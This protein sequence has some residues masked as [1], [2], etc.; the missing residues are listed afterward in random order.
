[1]LVSPCANSVP[2]APSP[3]V[4]LP[5]N[6]A[7]NIPP[8]R[9]R[10]ADKCGGDRAAQ[11]PDKGRAGQ[12]CCDPNRFSDKIDFLQITGKQR[13]LLYP[14]AGTDLLVEAKEASADAL[15]TNKVVPK[16][17][18]HGVIGLRKRPLKSDLIS[19][20]GAPVAVTHGLK[21][22]LEEPV[23]GGWESLRTAVGEELPPPDT[24]SD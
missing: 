16:S 9:G 21:F 10:N 1:M 12:G 19:P 17:M 18:A 3:A 23:I 7:P 24:P 15:C 5:V 20:A 6:V 8:I 22:V 11:G 4:F 14:A 13:L 2:S